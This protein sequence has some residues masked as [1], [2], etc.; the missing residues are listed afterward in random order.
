MP[1]MSAGALDSDRWAT[2][3]EQRH[4][5]LE[6]RRDNDGKGYVLTACGW[7]VWPSR[8]DARLVDPR[9]CLQCEYLAERGP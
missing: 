4:V 7:L 6:R 5:V 3:A 2:V 1:R 9:T 8:T